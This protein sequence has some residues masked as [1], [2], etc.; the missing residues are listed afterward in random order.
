MEGAPPGAP[1]HRLR[2]P[3]AARPQQGARGGPPAAPGGPAAPG[4]RPGRQGGPRTRGSRGR[5]ESAGTGEDTLVLQ[6]ARLPGGAVRGAKRAPAASAQ[7]GA[8]GAASGASGA[9]GGRAQ[10]GKFG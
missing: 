3:G 1:T 9:A 4:A 10:L 6:P 8:S 2:D 7:S 5:Y